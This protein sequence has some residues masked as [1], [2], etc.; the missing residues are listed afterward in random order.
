[1]AGIFTRSPLGA[2]VRSPLGARNK[3]STLVGPLGAQVLVIDPN[4]D[5]L[6][7]FNFGLIPS[8]YVDV[9]GVKYIHVGNR[10]LTTNFV[11]L[12]PE[13]IHSIEVIITTS[14]SFSTVSALTSGFA[15]LINTFPNL[16]LIHWG[17]D[18]T[19]LDT[20]RRD[21]FSQITG[22]Q[23]NSVPVANNLYA[24]IPPEVDPSG[25]P[26]G[27]Q[28]IGWDHSTPGGSTNLYSGPGSV[29]AST[30]DVF[31]GDF[32]PE[33][34]DYIWEPHPT[35]TY[36]AEYF[37]GIYTENPFRPEANWGVKGYTNGSPIVT[38]ERWAGYYYGYSPGTVYG[39]F[40]QGIPIAVVVSQGMHI[41]GRWGRA[42]ASLNTR[43]FYNSFF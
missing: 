25:E 39:T 40:Q 24:T 10:Q 17:S 38:G 32:D 27:I 2:F 6:F 21:A 9:P 18:M 35:V 13:H 28:A 30:L 4:S 1:M 22:I 41:I 14:L 20:A 43:A 8:P 29:T 31:T 15:N 23:Y 7:G 36:L 16:R 3:G 33:V 42:V 19:A 26:W 5:L 34:G 37:T 11:T 12:I